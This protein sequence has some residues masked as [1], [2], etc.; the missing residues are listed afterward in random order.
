LSH[1]ENTIPYIVQAIERGVDVEIDVW[2]TNNKL[3]LGHDAP[4]H[5]VDY[6]FLRYYSDRLW[7]HCKNIDALSYMN[8]TPLH[9]FWHQEDTYTLT[10][11]GYIWCYPGVPTTEKCIIVLKDDDVRSDSNYLGICSDYVLSIK[12]GKLPQERGI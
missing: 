7:I 1:Q 4:E 5:D 9:Y 8:G 2:A 12:H 11:R 6:D 3:M 10:S